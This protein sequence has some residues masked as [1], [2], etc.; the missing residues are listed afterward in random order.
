MVDFPEKEC[1]FNDLNDA[2]ISTE[3][4]ERGLKVYRAFNM[5]SMSQYLLLY[6]TSVSCYISIYIYVINFYSMYN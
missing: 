1:F 4:Y 6:N 3:D 2:H 5:T